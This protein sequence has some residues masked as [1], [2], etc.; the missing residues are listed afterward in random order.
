[1]IERRYSA[2]LC[3]N[4]RSASPQ[5]IAA[6]AAGVTLQFRKPEPVR[7]PSPL[8]D[9]MRLTFCI[10]IHHEDTPQAT[11]MPVKLFAG[12]LRWK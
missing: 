8:G 1:M 7:M 2:N 3:W 10:P 5:T 12:Y 11:A 4:L 6:H 9:W